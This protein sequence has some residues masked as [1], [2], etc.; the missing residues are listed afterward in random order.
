MSSPLRTALRLGRVSNLP[1]VWT[2]V[3]AGL[4]LNGGELHP[5]VIIPLGLATSLFYV[6]G[7]YLNDAFDWRWDAQHRPER[8]IP[9]GEI[10]A[11]AVFAAGFAMMAAG[12]VLLAV[13]PGSPA[14][15]YGGLGLAACILVYDISH[16][17]NPLA[18]VVMGLCRVSV[19]VIAGLAA[20][21]MLKTAVYVGAGLQLLYLI[22]LT[23]VARHEHKNPKLPRLVGLMIAGI[24]LLDAAVLLVVGHPVAAAI[25]AAGFPLTRLFQ[26][27]IAGT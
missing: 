19:Y 3:M 2:N 13:G 7:M 27:K 25:A 24:S 5:R 8:P 14:P 12:L 9:A 10:S 17:R 20:A 4:A 15:F 23:L 16:K 1:T 11:R 26:R 21:P 18:P 22:E 6:A